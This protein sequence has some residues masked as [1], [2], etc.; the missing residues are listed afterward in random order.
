[1]SLQVIVVKNFGNTIEIG[2]PHDPKI[3]LG[4]GRYFVVPTDKLE[5]EALST[6][7]CTKKVL[8]AYG[9]GKPVMGWAA[10]VLDAFLAHL[11]AK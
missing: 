5:R 11:E 8:D 4:P 9:D 6:A 7:L 2:D 1:M 10:E 3:V